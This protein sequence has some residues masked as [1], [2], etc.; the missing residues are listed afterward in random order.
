MKRTILA[1]IAVIFS[2]TFAAAISDS[3]LLTEMA[4]N[5]ASGTQISAATLRSFLTDLVN[6]K[7]NNQNIPA[8]PSPGVLV[9]SGAAGTATGLAPSS[10]FDSWYCSTVGYVIVRWTGAWTCSKS[11]AANPVWWGADPTGSSNSDSAFNSALAA[12]TFVQFPA[13]KFKF[14]GQISYTVSASPGSVN[15]A[16]AGAET[17]I[18]YWPTGN[19]LSFSLSTPKQ[20]FH[21]HDLTLSTGATPGGAA[22]AVTSSSTS[23]TTLSDVT[24][25][26]CRG[27][28]FGGNAGAGTEYW[29]YCANI[30]VLNGVSFSNSVF[31]GS[32]ASGG[33]GTGIAIAGNNP[34]YAFDYIVN[35]STFVNLKYGIA[36]GDYFQG[37]QVTNSSFSGVYGIDMLSNSGIICC[38]NVSN[39]QFT[40]SVAGLGTQGSS[41]LYTY[42]FA[43]NLFFVGAGGWAI[44]ITN[45]GGGNITGNAVTPNGGAGASGNTGFALGNTATNFGA[46]IVGN[47]I[48]YMTNGIVLT[49]GS[50]RASVMGN[51]ITN[52]TNPVVTL[53]SS[54]NQIIGN[55]GYNPIGISTGAWAPATTATYTAG[56]MSETHYLT[57][58]TVTAVK[59]PNN[60]GTTVCTGTPCTVHLGPNETMSITYTGAPTDTKSVH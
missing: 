52:T 16:G 25:I 49:T 28:D 7:V 54:N 43:N 24:N 32:N 34:T 47:T 1:V 5:L 37:L 51:I 26:S 33:L 35:G 38:I 44:N 14:S 12:N 31:L 29:T 60:A 58:G 46:S 56:F 41:I 53:S 27:D 36:L 39:T 55:V 42:Q 19:G 2:A 30:S 48:Y 3:A 11:I 45:D 22:I 8:S 9:P 20:S 15:I 57:G 17:T 6:S 13:G 18:L 4:T 59:I 50:A 21:V 23:V 40:E 10:A